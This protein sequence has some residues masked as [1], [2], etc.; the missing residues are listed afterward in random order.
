MNNFKK[1]GLTALGTSLIASSAYAGALSVTGSA[2]ITFSGNDSGT[3]GNNFSMSD[4]VTFSGGGEM[5]NGWNVTASYELDNNENVTTSGM[6]SY[7][8]KIDT[9]GMGVVTFSGHGGDTV[10]SGFDDM[11]PTAYEE[12]FALTKN[13]SDAATGAGNLTVAGQTANNTWRYDSPSVGG[14]QFSVAYISA[15]TGTTAGRISSYSDMGI[16]ISPE[17]VEGLTI[18]FATGE[19]DKSATTL[20]L[21]HSTM[22]A[23]YAYGSMT[24]GYQSSEIDGPTA[25]ASDESTSWA[26]S[27][28]V[29]DD[30][31]VSYGQH[32]YEQGTNA[33]AQE[34][35]GFSASYTM[36]GTTISTAF[37]ETENIRGAAANDEDSFEIALSFAF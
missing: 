10:M 8:L 31:S 6:D 12:V 3:G 30:F 33:N 16:K 20:G 26:V 27:Y 35:S 28:A 37:N 15:D 24:V 32:E 19:Y 4:S 23:T 13:K 17:A 25:A 29:S 7:S 5:D 14:A 36:G 11:M 18:G 9:N 22:F 34:S 2:S 1:I 21:D